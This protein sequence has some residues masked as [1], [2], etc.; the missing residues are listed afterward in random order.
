MKAQTNFMTVENDENDYK[1]FIKKISGDEILHFETTIG[2]L[3]HTFNNRSDK[4]VREFHFG[5]TGNALLFPYFSNLCKFKYINDGGL[6]YLNFQFSFNFSTTNK[7]LCIKELSE[8]SSTENS[9]SNTLDGLSISRLKRVPYHISC[10]DN[11]KI[12][13]S[14]KYTIRG[15]G[16]SNKYRFFNIMLLDQNGLKHKPT[17]DFGHL[18][19]KDWD[20]EHWNRFDKYMINCVGK[21]LKQGLVLGK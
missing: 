18:L 1:K 10:E 8:N 12:I 17:D 20:D 16:Q 14:S 11:S 5:G 15:D 2:Y 3:L 21:Y 19:F 4:L 6:T 13:V 7:I 9:S